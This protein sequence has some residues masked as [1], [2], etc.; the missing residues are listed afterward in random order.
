MKHNAVT[1]LFPSLAISIAAPLILAA[2]PA[3][4]E[5]NCVWDRSKIEYLDCLDR[6][7]R[8]KASELDKSLDYA[9]SMLEGK[10]LESFNQGQTHWEKFLEANC[11]AAYERWDG[12]SIA[13]TEAAACKQNLTKQRAEEIRQTFYNPEG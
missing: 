9:R 10:A 2:T 6:E 7:K 1:H 5:S 3:L 12:G 11:N 4:A 13:S 8:A